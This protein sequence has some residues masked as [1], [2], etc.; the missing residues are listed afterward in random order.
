MNIIS[1]SILIPNLNLIR[2]RVFMESSNLFLTFSCKLILILISF[3]L[4]TVIWFSDSIS[5]I[6]INLFILKL[7][8]YIIS[9]VFPTI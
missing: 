7:L 4:Y 8:E 6:L 3:I 1:E 5:I 2:G 9:S